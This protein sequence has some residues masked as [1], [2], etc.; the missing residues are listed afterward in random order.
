MELGSW[1]SDVER[2][3]RVGVWRRVDWQLAKF[4]RTVAPQHSTR[5]PTFGSASVPLL[6]PP[7]SHDKVTGVSVECTAS[8]FKVC[9][10][11]KRFLKM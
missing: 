6:E 3:S 5:P 11:K 10:A 9:Q 4:R 8:F 7:V 2:L 1:N